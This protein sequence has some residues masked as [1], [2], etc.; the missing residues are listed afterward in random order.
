[1][2]RAG[3]TVGIW[4]FGKVGRSVAGLMHTKGYSLLVCDSTKPDS[5]L[6]DQYNAQY[7]TQEELA[8]FFKHSDIII[9]SPGIDIRPY[10]SEI[11]SKLEPELDLFA[12]F[13][14]NPLYAITGSV[15][16]TTVTTLLGEI[17]KKINPHTM[18][19]G[20][21]GYAALNLLDNALPQSEA[22]LEVSSFQLEF[23]RIFAPDLAIITNLHPNHLDRHTTMQAYTAAK[24]SMIAHQTPHQ[25]ILIPEK[26]W[27]TT[28]T[29]RDFNRENVG[30]F[31]QEKP[32]EFFPGITYYWLEHTKLIKNGIPLFNITHLASLTFLENILII[33][34]A[35]DMLG[36]NL[37]T[38]DLTVPITLIP[39]HR[40]EPIVNSRGITIYNDSK[41]TTIASTQAALAR[42]GGAPT[43]LLVGG[44]SK[45][46]DRSALI[47]DLPSSIR[48]VYC[49]GKEA[50]QLARWCAEYNK[51][52]SLHESLES[53]VTASIQS[54]TVGDVILFS[55]AGSSFDLF[56]NF[57]ER[58]T[59]F[60]DL[61]H[62]VLS[63]AV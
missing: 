59:I 49:F 53:A 4:G 13:W 41:S 42:V 39:A 36:H 38:L 56:Q 9:P 20:N 2:Q 6:L 43:H 54:S 33:C 60:K 32:T 47:K 17:L 61:V 57:E 19:G 45:G 25:R 27:P 28:H 58:G 15:G 30:L 50:S 51:P 34:A 37:G 31:S 62:R 7:F 46:T 18:V 26:L 3:K 35:L 21:I 1:M 48:H 12:R 63:S 22:L 11:A 52:H 10:Y 29:L 16:K 55:P 24:L 5:T 8:L 40:M 23:S 44:L 14:K